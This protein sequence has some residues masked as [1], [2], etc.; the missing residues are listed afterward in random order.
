[1][2]SSL[3]SILLTVCSALVLFTIIAIVAVVVVVVIVVIVVV[4]VVAV[5]AIAI[6]RCY[7]CISH[8]LFVSL[9]PSHHIASHQEQYVSLF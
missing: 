8:Y 6:S 5:V 3:Q 1:L 2:S 7:H 9:S 4:I